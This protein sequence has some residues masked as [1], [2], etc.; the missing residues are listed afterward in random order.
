MRRILIL[1]T[2]AACLGFAPLRAQFGGRENEVVL[3]AV[4]AKGN[5]NP[6]IVPANTVNT[7]AGFQVKDPFKEV[8]EPFGPDFPGEFFVTLHTESADHFRFILQKEGIVTQHN[9]FQ[10][11]A[12]LMIVQGLDRLLIPN[13]EPIDLT[14]GLFAPFPQGVDFG[15]ELPIAEAN[16]FMWTPSPVFPLLRPADPSFI[17][18]ITPAGITGSEYVLQLGQFAALVPWLGFNDIYGAGWPQGVD[19]RLLEQDN[20]L[21]S[22]VRMIRLRP[23][24]QTPAFVIRANTHLAVLQGSVQVRPTSGAAVTLTSKMYA[25]IPNGFAISLAN[26]VTYS[27]PT[28]TSDKGKE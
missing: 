4:S 21:G 3:L 6:V 5:P 13:K 22:T 16:S 11:P 12:K 10:G 20:L 25:F 19:Q 1:S 9:T 14:A 15:P 24:R 17:S 27:G 18:P 8:F 7:Q 26:P 28:S 23:G 2:L